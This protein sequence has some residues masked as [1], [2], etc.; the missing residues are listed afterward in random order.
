MSKE[1]L[2]NVV[3]V[4]EVVLGILGILCPIFC[5]T[6]NLLSGENLLTSVVFG[7]TDALLRTPFLLI[8]MAFTVLERKMPAIEQDA[9][10]EVRFGRQLRSYRG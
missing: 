5:I 7:M 6:M 4:A 8:F 1:K 2:L 10:M 3:I 9:Y